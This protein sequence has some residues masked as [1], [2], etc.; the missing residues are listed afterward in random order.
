MGRSNWIQ[1]KDELEADDYEW[2]SRT[3]EDG[4]YEVRVVASDERGNTEA[5]KLT[6]SRVSDPVV[7]DNTGP[8]IRKYSIEKTGRTATLKLQITDELSA[9]GSLDYTIDSHDEWKGALPD[10][11]VFDTTD[12]SFTITTDDLEPGEHVIALRIKDD[13]DNTTYKTFEVSVVGK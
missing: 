3:V 4:R 6:G 8:V 12:E 1:M 10:D 5:T 9:I 13:V 11:F 7:V 2:D